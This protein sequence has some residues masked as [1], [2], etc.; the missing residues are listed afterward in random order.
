[1]NVAAYLEKVM[2]MAGIP[3]NICTR[4]VCDEPGIARHLDTLG[5]KITMFQK[6]RYYHSILWWQILSLKT[7]PRSMAR[8]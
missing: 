3:I 6:G 2:G 1:M 7:Y 8:K 4:I 5:N